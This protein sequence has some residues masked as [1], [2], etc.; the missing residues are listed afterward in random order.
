MRWKDGITADPAV[1]V[2]KPIIKGTRISVDFVLSL[3]AQGWTEDQI[4]QNYPQLQRE[5]LRALF[6][7]VQSCRIEE[8]YVA[9][10][11]LG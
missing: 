8:E 7:F 11:K 3:L 2:G 6:A 10:G 9:L 5:D 1:L 4:L